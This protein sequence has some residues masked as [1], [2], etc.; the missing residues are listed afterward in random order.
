S[1][2]NSRFGCWV[3]TVVEQDRSMGSLVR[4]DPANSW[5]YPLL[6]LRDELDP[7]SAEDKDRALRDFRRMNGAVHL[8][9]DRAVPGPYTQH[10]RHEW[11]RRVLDAKRSIRKNGPAD[12]RD[13]ELITLAELEEIRRLWVLEKH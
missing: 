8:Y 12:M 9:A 6:Q 10:V 5:L 3:C 2:G 1:C 11:L 7:R 4:N 13:L